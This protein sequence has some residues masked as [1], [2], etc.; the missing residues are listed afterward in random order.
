[1]PEMDGFEATR[2]IRELE[3][4]MCSLP[5]IAMTANAMQGDKQS[6]LDAGMSDYLSKPV[7]KPL[8]LQT[9]DEWLYDNYIRSTSESDNNKALQTKQNQSNDE[10]S[11][12]LVDIDV[13]KRLIKDTGGIDISY[14]LV[15][16][17]DETTARLNRIK[18][19]HAQHDYDIIGNETHV[20]KSSAG[21]YGLPL[22][23]DLATK[24]N[25]AYKVGDTNTIDDLISQLLDAGYRSI[26]E[27]V[28]QF[29]LKDVVKN[30]G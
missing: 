4:P 15:I 26:N 28:S 7:N 23:Q 5:I 6:C 18:L 8:L 30:V 20:I 22:L 25:Q 2:L 14:I 29:K 19:S 12:E 10:V 13:I 16:F 27:L 11:S 3:E 17:I 21:T 24:I 9:L 1:M